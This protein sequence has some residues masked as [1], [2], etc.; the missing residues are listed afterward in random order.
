MTKHHIFF[1]ISEQHFIPTGGIGSF[2]RGF[3][4]MADHIGWRVTVLIDKEPRKPGRKMMETHPSAG[5]VFPTDPESYAGYNPNPSPYAQDIPNHFKQANFETAL[6]DAMDVAKPSHILIN[7]PEAGLAVTKLGLHKSIPTTFY[8]HHENLFLNP[9]PKN[10]KFGPEYMQML[11]DI[12][13][14]RG[15]QT[16]T[17]SDFNIQRMTHL[18]LAKPAMVLPMPI[19]DSELLEPY[20]GVK[21]GV[22]F[23]GR[24]EPRKQPTVFARKVSQAGLPVKVLTNATGEKKFQ[25]TFKK[26]DITNYEIKHGIT[27]Q[28]KADFLRSARIAF[29]PAKLESY[30][31]SA[32]ETLAAGLPTLLV[33]EYGWWQSFIKEGVQ[34]TP[35]RQAQ[36]KLRE[37]YERPSLTAPAY[38]KTQEQQVF[39][40]WQSHFN[41]RLAQ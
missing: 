21:E 9:V 15:I 10:S 27:G 1:L 34:I 33:H 30:G 40:T 8:T 23:I 4:R 35:I 7:T 39:E 18:D 13:G 37:L 19:P 2:F 31:F 12:V 36:D 32:M 5:Y 24:H 25:A 17:Q 28:E 6:Q 26:Y 14:T 16:A 22:L 11:F 41:V 29:H 3:L 38:G 20:N